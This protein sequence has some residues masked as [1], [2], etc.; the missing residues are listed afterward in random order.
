MKFLKENN[1]IEYK[2]AKGGLPNSVWETYSAFANTDG[3]TIYLGIEELKNRELISSM[4]SEKNVEEL[5]IAFWTTI[6]NIEKVSANILKDEDVSIIEY[7]G[8]YVLKID[9]PRASRELRPVYL[10]NNPNTGS[11]K[12]NNEG[13]Y[14]CTLSEIKAMY[15]DAQDKPQDLLCLEDLGLDTLCNETIDSYRNRFGVLHRDHVFLNKSREEFLEFIGAI[16]MGK[17][18]NYHPTR[19]G[20]LM[21]GY[22]YKIVYEFP[23]YYLD[24]EEHHSEGSDVRWTDRIVSTSG[25]WSG[26]LFDFYN[27]TI[28]RMFSSVKLPFVMDG[29]NRKDENDLHVII[30][31]ALCNAICNGDFYLS[32]GLVINNYYDHFEISNP[33]SFRIELQDAYKG[34]VSDVRNK[35]IQKMFG[36]IGVGERAGSGIVTIM[37]ISRK[38]NLTMPKYELYISP[39]RVKLTVYLTEEA[40]TDK[41]EERKLQ[42]LSYLENNDNAKAKD[43][44]DS[45]NMNITT[46]KKELYQLLE[47]GQISSSGTIK[48]KRYFL[49]SRK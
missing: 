5:R 2:K 1:R 40:K 27:K 17:D 26:N 18:G 19:A 7:Q 46:L 24:Y 15:R 42:I 9:V 11:F 38:L 43:I 10:N 25:D 33:G 36:L 12:R 21:F 28:S 34:G 14:H 31:E 44:A 6:N 16:R 23:E 48:D 39:D 32:R 22:E 41:K 29:A 20:L 4:L 30:R 47:E 45:L 49:I 37:N 8:Y 35:T 3:G 13:D